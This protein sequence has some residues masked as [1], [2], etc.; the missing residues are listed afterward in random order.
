MNILK[1][2]GEINELTRKQN[3]CGVGN[4]QGVSV[5]ISEEPGTGGLPLP[6]SSLFFFLSLFMSGVILMRYGLTSHFRNMQ[7]S[8]E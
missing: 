2:R 8:L 5:A 4:A 7:F 6:L 1:R 3:C